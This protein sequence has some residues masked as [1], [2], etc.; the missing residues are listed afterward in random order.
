MLNTLTPATQGRYAA[1]VE[2]L[3]QCQECHRGAGRCPTAETL[4]QKYL[5]GF[6]KQ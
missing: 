2:H 5:A 3:N 6:S 1:Y 4:V